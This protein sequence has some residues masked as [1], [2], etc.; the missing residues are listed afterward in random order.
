MHVHMYICLV[1]QLCPTFCNPMNCNPPGCSVHGIFQEHLLEK[2]F[3]FLPP[4]NLP[5][6]L[7]SSALAGRFFTTA[8][9]GK[10]SVCA[11]V[12]VCLCVCVCVCEYKTTHIQGIRWINFMSFASLC[13]SR[14]LLTTSMLLNL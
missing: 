6:S 9:L 1:A 4:G 2:Y 14:N 3:L 5:I 11:C 10:S 13:C 7:A 8:P 12:Y